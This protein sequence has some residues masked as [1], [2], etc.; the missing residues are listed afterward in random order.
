MKL[1]YDTELPE[2]Q[3]VIGAISMVVDELKEATSNY[4]PFHSTHEGLAVILE[5]YRELEHEV[6]RKQSTYDFEKMRKEATQLAAMA[7]RFM[8]DCL[9]GTDE[10]SEDRDIDS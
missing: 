5:E 7:V 3:A 6:F 8:I 9:N 2:D 10:R 4:G 1:F